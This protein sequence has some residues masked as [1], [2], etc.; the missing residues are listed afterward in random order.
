[1]SMKLARWLVVLD[2]HWIFNNELIQYLILEVG[3]S[4]YTKLNEQYEPNINAAGR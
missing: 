1:M 4:I 2:R 3:H